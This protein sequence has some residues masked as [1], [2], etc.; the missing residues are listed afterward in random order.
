MPRH[1]AEDGLKQAIF[2]SVLPKCER[3]QPSVPK[4]DLVRML[5]SKNGLGPRNGEANS[6]RSGIDV[7]VLAEL[8]L[9][10]E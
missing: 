7:C 3:C 8:K 5:K 2:D 10:I 9:E 4:K 1:Q 6:N